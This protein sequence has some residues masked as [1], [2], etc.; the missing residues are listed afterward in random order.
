MNE[1][2]PHPAA[3][4]PAILLAACDE[5]RTRRSG[6][7]GQHRNKVET[8]VILRHPPTGLGA[9]ASERRSQAENRAV[10]LGRLRLRLAVGLRSD[11]LPGPA[12]PPSALWRGRVRGG[13]ITVATAHDDFPTLLAE[14][15]DSLAAA[16]WEPRDA[17]PR[18][19]V[20]PTQLVRLVAR[21]P[22]ALALVNRQRGALG[23][24]PLH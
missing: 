5:T 6:P 14:A 10:A 4:P 24:G 13:R 11:P 15:L 20:S 18:L 21:E 7:G 23:L 12:T 22:A 9:E 16:G 3:L 8:A 17:A 1:P 2:A 19:A